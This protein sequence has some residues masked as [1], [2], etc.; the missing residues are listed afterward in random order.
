[1]NQ[2]LFPFAFYY[3]GSTY[4]NMQVAA[5]FQIFLLFYQSAL[6]VIVLYHSIKAYRLK[7]C[8]NVIIKR[9]N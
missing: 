5:S 2:T 9:G 4:T 3:L 7:P 8:P 1:M 6:S